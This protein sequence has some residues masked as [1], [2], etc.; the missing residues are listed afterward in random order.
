[1]L[2]A[3]AINCTLKPSPAPS[4]TDVLLDQVAD[5]FRKHDV[6]MEAIRLA[7]MTVN[8][9]VTSEEGE[10]DDWPDIRRKVLAADIFILATPI[11][12]GHPS[13]LAQ[14]VLERMDAFISETDDEGRMVS[15]GRVAGVVVVGNEDGAHHVTAELY[16]GLADLGFTIAAN[17]TTYWVGR[18]MQ[19]TDYIDLDDVP[20][21]TERATAMMTRNMAHLARLLKHDQYPGDPAAEED[22]G[23]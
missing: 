12:I 23:S 21:E 22:D 4:S 3:V 16:Q 1:M 11:W 5:E 9:G 19:S 2:K 18:A 6:E 10:D 17:S 7:D 13:S 20:E 8:P 15:Y 14:R